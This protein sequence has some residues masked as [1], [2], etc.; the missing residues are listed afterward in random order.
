MLSLIELCDDNNVRNLTTFCEAAKNLDL[1]DLCERYER[2]RDKA[3]HRALA[4]KSYLI[5]GHNGVPSSGTNSNRREEHLALALHNE[6]GSGI[7][8]L[9][10]DHQYLNII[11][12]QTPMKAS[13]SDMR[14]GKI[15]LLGI[16]DQSKLCV[17]ELKIDGRNGSRADTPLRALLEGLAYCAIVDANMKDIANDVKQTRQFAVSLK[18][19]ILIVMAPVDYW[20]EYLTHAKAGS[21]LPEFT[22]IIKYLIKYLKKHLKIDIQLIGIK[23]DGFE[24]GSNGK[25]PVLTGGCQFVSVQQISDSL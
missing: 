9:L 3:P 21:W 8:F 13:Q 20:I 24:M 2:A 1:A 10:P 14:V 18:S 17:I 16:I 11:D 15:D 4:N 7:P 6:S 12:Y 19:P 25:A 5:D 22:R 23:Y